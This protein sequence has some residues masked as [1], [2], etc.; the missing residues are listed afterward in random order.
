[1]SKVTSIKNW[2]PRPESK[3]QIVHMVGP[4]PPM[5]NVQAILSLKFRRPYC[6]PRTKFSEFWNARYDNCKSKSLRWCKRCVKARPCKE[7]NK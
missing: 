1:M 5:G 2:R 4:M 7:S 3:G 6:A